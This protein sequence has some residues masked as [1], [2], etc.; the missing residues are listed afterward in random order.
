MPNNTIFISH[1]SK[2]EPIIR[3]F[4]KKVLNAGLGINR[5]NIF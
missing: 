1:S 5:D 2:D 3:V 4:I